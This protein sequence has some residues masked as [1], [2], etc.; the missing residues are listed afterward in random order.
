VGL[1]GKIQRVNPSKLTIGLLENL[2]TETPLSRRDPPF[3]GNG[4][5][6]TRRITQMIRI[7][8]GSAADAEPQTSCDIVASYTAEHFVN[9]SDLTQFGV[10]NVEIQ[11]KR[12]CCT[13]NDSHTG[14]ESCLEERVQ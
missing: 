1:T 2:N 14:I 3:Q 10:R 7:P 9:P 8:V 5:F 12:M 13:D 4:I 11:S 6:A